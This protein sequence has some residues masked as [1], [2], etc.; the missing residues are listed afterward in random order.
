M[1]TSFNGW[2]SSWGGAWGPISTNPNDMSASGGF[3]LTGTAQL[4]ALLFAQGGGSLSI[5]ATGSLTGA[6]VTNEMVGAATFTFSA[7][8]ILTDPNA[9]PD[10][11]PKFTNR[12]KLQKISEGRAWLIHAKSETRA[13]ALRAEGWSPPIVVQP[14][15][16]GA[17]RA[18][19][20]KSSVRSG[21]IRA[22]AGAAV[23]LR[24]STS[25]TAANPVG[26]KASAAVKLLRSTT[27]TNASTLLAT[28]WGSGRLLTSQ[29]LS[30]C[31]RVRAKGTRGISDVE[32]VA[33]LRVVDIRR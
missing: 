28:G 30:S 27:D 21:T 5:N 10:R 20:C 29:S 16:H 4:T 11:R 15:L 6:A 25:D 3:V 9:Y 32:L 12:I 8:G 24:T 17:V 23:T 19:G 18:M 33:A 14:T 31:E 22:R 26:V 2:G 13:R 1:A 7:I